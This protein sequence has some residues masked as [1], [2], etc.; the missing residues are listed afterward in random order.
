MNKQIS[1]RPTNYESIEDCRMLAKWDADPKIRHLAMPQRDEH[2]LSNPKSA[3]QIQKEEREKSNDS[4]VDLLIMSDEK[5][6][7]HC[8]IQFDPPHRLIKTGKVAWFGLTIGEESFRYKGIGKRVMRHLEELAIL[9]GANC[10][11][12]GV[13]EFNGPSLKMC[14][15][16]GYR[17]FGRIEKFTYWQGKYWADIR[18]LKQL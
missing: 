2:S 4:M 1:Y 16:L 10:I 15:A 18:L 14:L 3:E 9:H 17:E 5:A 12:V 11:E 13:F 8:S 6:I 7:G